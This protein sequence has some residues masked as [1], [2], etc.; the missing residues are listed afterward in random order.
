MTMDRKTGN[1]ILIGMIA[2]AILGGLGGY[3]L[4]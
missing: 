2:A 3:Y 1:L 4:P